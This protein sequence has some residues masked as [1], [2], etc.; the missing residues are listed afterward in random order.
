MSI[1]LIY[2]QAYY[3]LAPHEQME[4]RQVTIED[5][6][7]VGMCKTGDILRVMRNVGG[8]GG[9]RLT[10]K[11]FSITIFHKKLIVEFPD[12]VNDLS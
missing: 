11:D 8:G 4:L 3:A 5:H 9:H 6:N 7:V 10:V 2:R 1:L 12:G